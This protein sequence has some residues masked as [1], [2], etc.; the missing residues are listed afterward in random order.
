LNIEFDIYMSHTKVSKWP[1]W[2]FLLT[3]LYR[4]DTGFRK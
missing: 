4:V 3:V 1:K 2:V